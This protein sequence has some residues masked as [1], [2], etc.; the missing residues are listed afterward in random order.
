M[1]DNFSGR[2]EEKIQSTLL[3]YHHHFRSNT[4]PTVHASCTHVHTF[5]QPQPLS[6]LS[7]SSSEWSTICRPSGFAPCTAR[8]AWSS[9]MGSP[10]GAASS[11]SCAASLALR[12]SMRAA[13]SLAERSFSASSSARLR[14]AA[15]RAMRISS[16]RAFCCAAS[17]SCL[18]CACWQMNKRMNG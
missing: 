3:C 14:S 8:L 17:A 6:S 15:S 13:S 2:N 12:A 9:S 10:L 1:L 4:A 18:A 7:L 16:S 5:L 11:S